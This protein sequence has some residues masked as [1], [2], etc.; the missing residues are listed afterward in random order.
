MTDRHGRMGIMG[1]QAFPVKKTLGQLKI[2]QPMLEGNGR[3]WVRVD[4]ESV[5]R[6]EGA[7]PAW[8]LKSMGLIPICDMGGNVQFGPADVVVTAIAGGTPIDDSISYKL[9]QYAVN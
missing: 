1:S 9:W 3:M 6:Y 2:G 7:L 4:W 8:L 5:T